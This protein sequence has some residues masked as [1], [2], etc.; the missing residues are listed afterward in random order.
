MC[1]CHVH[2]FAP[3]PNGHIKRVL[4]HLQG[5]LTYRRSPQLAHQ[6]ATSQQR[7]IHAHSLVQQR[8]LE[9]VWYHHHAAILLN[10]GIY[11]LLESFEAI[12]HEVEKPA[13]FADCRLAWIR[14]PQRFFFAKSVGLKHPAINFCL[15]QLARS[16]YCTIKLLNA[17]ARAPVRRLRQSFGSFIYR[18]RLRIKYSSWYAVPDRVTAC[19]V[20]RSGR[21]AVAPSAAIV[22]QA[23]I[24]SVAQSARP[25]SR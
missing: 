4:I 13:K 21:L 20:I 18:P 6:I 10:E 3:R 2:D 7:W 19:T 14:I 16:P 15:D 12:I 25:T 8:M 17:R 11:A 24:R 1:D 5:V 23:R 9:L 22:A